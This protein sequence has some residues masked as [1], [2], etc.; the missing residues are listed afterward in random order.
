MKSPISCENCCSFHGP[1][2]FVWKEPCNPWW[3]T[4]CKQQSIVS[5]KPCCCSQEDI[6]NIVVS[7]DNHIGFMEKDA[8][9]R[10]D[11]F[12]AFEEVLTTAKAQKVQHYVKIVAAQLISVRNTSIRPQQCWPIRTLFRRRI[13]CS[14]RAT[15]TTRTSRRGRPS[16]GASQNDWQENGIHAKA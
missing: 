4:G 6:I 7:T 16:F 11:S 5:L 12:L 14:L 9:R 8:I 15:C 10:D 2:N 1:R 3:N 13:W